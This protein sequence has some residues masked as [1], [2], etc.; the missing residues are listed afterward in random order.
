MKIPKKLQ[1][2]GHVQT[3]AWLPTKSRSVR[4]LS[5]WSGDVIIGVNQSHTTLFLFPNDVQ[6]S[7]ENDSG[8]VTKFKAPSGTLKKLGYAVQI[9]YQSNL[10]EGKD[11][12]Y[13]HDFERESASMWGNAITR[14]SVIAIKYPKGVIVTDRGIV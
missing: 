13:Y 4:D 1:I 7:T 9:I 5:S 2:I 10:W 12:L 8:T 14:P 3:I 6:S 11:Q